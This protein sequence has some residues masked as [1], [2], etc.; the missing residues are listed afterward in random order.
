MREFQDAWAAVDIERMVSL[1][2]P[3]ALLAMP[4]E[5]ARFSGAAAIGEFFA[6]VPLA[7]R[8][9]R[10]TLVSARANGQPATAAY[11]EEPDGRRRAYGVMVFAIRGERVTGITGFA[12]QPDLFTRLGLPLELG[13]A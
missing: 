7:G 10:I 3:D 9:D 8:L 5:A 12:R 6:T 4:P 13:G 2:D 11:A 1:L